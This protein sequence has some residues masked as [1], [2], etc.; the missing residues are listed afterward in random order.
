MVINLCKICF[1]SWC[2]VILYVKG[3]GFRE[4]DLVFEFFKNVNNI[5]YKE[6]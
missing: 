4:D 1:D 2:F 3:C 6:L 5:V